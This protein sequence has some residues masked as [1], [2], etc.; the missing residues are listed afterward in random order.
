MR[1][2]P[3][4]APLRSRG[5]PSCLRAQFAAPLLVE[6]R[7]IL[8]LDLGEQGGVAVDPVWLAP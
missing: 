5:K 3:R 4:A 2:D 7:G 1:A 6:P 8:K